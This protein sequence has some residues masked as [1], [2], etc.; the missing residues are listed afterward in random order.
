MF[1]DCHAGSSLC[2]LII[3][4]VYSVFSIHALSAAN[5]RERWNCSYV[6]R[7]WNRDENKRDNFIPFQ[8]CLL[9]GCHCPSK[10]TGC[11]VP[12]CISRCSSKLWITSLKLKIHKSSL[13]II[14][15]LW[16][17]WAKWTNSVN[18]N[19]SSR[20]LNVFWT[21][22]ALC[23]FSPFNNCSSAVFFSCYCKCLH[24]NVTYITF[25]SLCKS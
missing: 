20:R 25:Q 24:S 18:F 11:Q 3:P 8:F 22:S 4:L 7:F 14:F 23:M 6:N 19:E 15:C 2:L 13:N 21:V 10:V 16:Y 12:V 9:S 5:R 17:C 1:L